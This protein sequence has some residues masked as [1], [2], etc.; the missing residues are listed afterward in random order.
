MK[1]L[2]LRAGL[3]C[4]LFAQIP[5]HAAP[6]TG[7]AAVEASATATTLITDAATLEAELGRKLK[8]RERMALKALNKRLKKAERKA[9]Q[10]DV[11]MRPVTSSAAIVGMISGIVSIFFAGILLGAVGVIF[12]LIAL[13]NIRKSGGT[14][15]GN[16]LAI[17]GLICGL[18]GIVGAFLI[19]SMGLV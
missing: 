18:V 19:I 6:T 1:S 17:T 4:L 11:V 7:R 10:T 3:F 14:L 16:G 12:S 9:A 2:L 5:A 8:W 15:K 13:S